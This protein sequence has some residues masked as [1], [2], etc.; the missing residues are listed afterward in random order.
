TGSTDLSFT[1]QNQ[2]TLS[3]LYDFMFRR[4]SPVQGRWISPDPAGMGA[5]DPSNPQTLLGP[6]F[7]RMRT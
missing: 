5:V 1:G 3:G 6:S 4:Y 7:G 2:D